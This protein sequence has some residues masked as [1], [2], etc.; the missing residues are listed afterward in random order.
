MWGGSGNFK[1]PGVTNESVG[2]PSSTGKEGVSTVGVVM[3]G[4]KVGGGDVAGMKRI[5]ERGG[6]QAGALYVSVK[7]EWLPDGFEVTLYHAHIRSTH[8]DT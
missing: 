8:Q 6:V 3:D 1:D 7:E 2:T 5:T 4:D